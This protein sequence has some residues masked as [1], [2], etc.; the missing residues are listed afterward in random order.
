[1]SKIEKESDENQSR[2]DLEPES[3]PDSIRPKVT[4]AP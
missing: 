4:A 1:M 2:F 3:L